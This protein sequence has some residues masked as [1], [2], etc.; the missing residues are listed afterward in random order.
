[1]KEIL[2]G[3]VQYGREKDKLM[4]FFFFFEEEDLLPE[5]YNLF[6]LMNVYSWNL[7]STI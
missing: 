6:T 7:N 1:M 4:C 2:K 3:C 5:I